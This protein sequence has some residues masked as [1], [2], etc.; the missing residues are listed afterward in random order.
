MTAVVL[1]SGG[2]DSTVALAHAMR[3]HA[4]VIALSF[5]YGQTHRIE[6]DHAAAIAREYRVQQ[7]ILD[8]KPILTA[9]SALTGHGDIPEHHATNVDETLVPGRNLIMLAIGVSFAAHRGAA[10]VVIGANK[11]DNAGYPDCRPGF[12]TSVDQTAR[13]STEGK[14]GVWAPLLRMTKTD[15]VQYAH[16]IG[17]P[18]S[19]T[20]S[21]YRGQDKPCDRCGACES[22][23]KALE[24]AQ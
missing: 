20:Y 19:M 15:I 9:P 12:L 8:L 11:D 6:L 23:N 1:L 14:V 22:R 21:C 5:D 16:I 10:N 4:T 7:H 2:I 18:I 13:Q 17:A 3:H 24:A